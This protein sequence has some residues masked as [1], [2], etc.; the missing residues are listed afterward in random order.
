MEV[1]TFETGDSDFLIWYDGGFFYRKAPFYRK[2]RKGKDAKCAKE[3][4]AQ[5][6]LIS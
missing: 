3:Q 4:R 2:V 1:L 5:R 6:T